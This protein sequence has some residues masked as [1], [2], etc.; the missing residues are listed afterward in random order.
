MPTVPNTKAAKEQFPWRPT[1]EEK[2][3]TCAKALGGCGMQG[4]SLRTCFNAP[5]NEGLRAKAIAAGDIV[6]PPRRTRW[7]PPWRPCGSCVRRVC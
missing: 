7:W 2:A 4:H 5:G 1:A 6:P 3:G